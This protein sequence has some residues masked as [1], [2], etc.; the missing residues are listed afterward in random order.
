MLANDV[1]GHE[2]A[3]EKRA[4]IA[5]AG[6]GWGLHLVRGEVRGLHGAQRSANS[7][8]SAVTGVNVVPVVLREWCPGVRSG[9]VCGN[10]FTK[11]SNCLPRLPGSVSRLE[12]KS[13]NLLVIGHRP[14]APAP[15]MRTRCEV[16]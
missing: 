7:L 14:P 9:S 1:L 11:R 4:R 5:P 15:K 3:E 16:F 2:A 8:T 6:A 10:H 12:R 13:M